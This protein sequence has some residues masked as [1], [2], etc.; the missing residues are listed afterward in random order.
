MSL[1][2]YFDH[3]VRIEI[4]EGLRR[5]GIDV[6]TAREDGTQRLADSELLDRATQ[7][8][9]VLFSQDRHL[10]AEA[11]RRQRS[12]LPFAGVIFGR[13][14]AM[15]IGQCIDE[16]EMVA[17]VYDPADMIDHVEYIPIQ[18]KI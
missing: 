18:G 10:L 5:R 9:R 4:A 14:L 15:T 3:N 2:L 17:S 11:A 16:L 12:S 8:G 6:V 7:L 1:R 13:Q